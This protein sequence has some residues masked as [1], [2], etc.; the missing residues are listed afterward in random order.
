[1]F[2]TS[3][4]KFKIKLVLRLAGLAYVPGEGASD[5]ETSPRPYKDRRLLANNTGLT[6][7]NLLSPN[8]DQDQ[9]SPYNIGT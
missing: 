8:S 3:T 7:L 6:F 2:L 1:M 9:Y 4:V 5:L